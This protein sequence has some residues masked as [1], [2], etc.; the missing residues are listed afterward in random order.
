MAHFAKLNTQNKVIAV[1]VVNNDVFTTEDEGIA[2]LESLYGQEEGITWKQTSYNTV[3]GTHIKGGTP[4]RMNYA[5]I[6]GWYNSEDDAFYGPQPH[7]S[8]TLNTDT[9]SWEEPVEYPTDGESYEWN[10]QTQS[11]DA[12]LTTE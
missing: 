7:P 6:G 8:W 4:L 1:H 10:E 5:A 9:Y 3:G 12:L 11:W 2:F